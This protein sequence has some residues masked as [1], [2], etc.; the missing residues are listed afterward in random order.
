MLSK[1]GEI[2]R[3]AFVINRV[4]QISRELF[5][6]TMLYTRH[7]ARWVV[8]V[9]EVSTG[10]EPWLDMKGVPL[11]GI[12][13]HGVPVRAAQRALER[14]TGSSAAAKRIS[15]MAVG[16]DAYPGVGTLSWD[17]D[18][19]AEAAV[20]LFQR[21]GCQHI[22]YVGASDTSYL[23]ASRK[24]AKSVEA[25]ARLKGFGFSAYRRRF[26][27]KGGLWL[28][29]GGD[30]LKWVDELPKPCGILAWDDRIGRNVSDLCRLNGINIPGSVYLLCVGDDDLICEN[31][32][33]TLSSIS[34]DIER[35]AFLAAKALDDMIDRK[36]A[37][38]P[39]LACGVRVLTERASTQDSRG[40]GRLVALACEFIAKNAC[41]EGG[42]NQSE[43][44]AH[45]GVSTRTLQMRF[46]E[47]AFARTILQE[48]HRVQ[49]ER[50][51]RLLSTSD[52]P[53]SEI[54][55]SSGFGSLSR[56]KA[57]F[58]K[59]YGMSMRDYRKLKKIPPP[60]PK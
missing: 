37:I 52:M 22:A 2:R 26:S 42:L 51:C 47:A 24:V 6:G 60:P 53:I 19:V 45:L 30:F 54:T 46:K 44:A 25:Q 1:I 40:S 59:T 8:R 14:L 41:R 15:I 43:I 16:Q 58:Q 11:D 35:T 50:V 17:T 3:I 38:P 13:L 36:F 10:R 9:F 7:N 31:T 23:R 57:L 29:S 49:L 27:K 55:Y 21:R 20:G 5:R 12:I 28:Q 33:P 32:S 39:H 56:L 18:G 34:L 4:S 48:V